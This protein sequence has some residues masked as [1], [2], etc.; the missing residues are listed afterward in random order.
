MAA[1]SLAARTHEAPLPFNEGDADLVG[2]R[3]GQRVDVCPDDYAKDPCTGELV[4]LT[5]EQVVID[6]ERPGDGKTRVAFP[7]LGYIIQASS[8]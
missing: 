4:G 3:R 7:R 5:S 8:A 1:E 6:V 2:V